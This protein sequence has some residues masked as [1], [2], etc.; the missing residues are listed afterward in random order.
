MHGKM[1]A[2]TGNPFTIFT[3]LSFCIEKGHFKLLSLIFI[4]EELSTPLTLSVLDS[5]GEINEESTSLFSNYLL[6]NVILSTLM[7]QIFRDSQ[8]IKSKLL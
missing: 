7:K 1:C 2:F 5:M 3:W 4:M 8:Q 6:K